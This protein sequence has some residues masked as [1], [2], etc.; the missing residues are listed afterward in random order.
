MTRT[1]LVI[2]VVLSGVLLGACGSSP[3]ASFYT[4]KSDAA[5]APMVS[6]APAKPVQV[7]I[8]AVTIPGVVDRPQIVTLV[9]DNQVALDEFARWGEPL[10][11]NIARAIAGDLARL[12]GSD[13]VSVFDAGMDPANTWRVRVDV[14]R[15]DAT[16]GEAVTIE[17][18]WALVAPGKSVPVVG[19][20][21]VR[22]QMD[23]HGNDALVSAADRAL[24]AVSHDIAAVIQAGSPQ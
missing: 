16:P 23:G 12:L 13:R 18:L 2:L 21:L 24:G 5:L 3:T 8:S 11:A 1:A 17:A 10:K 20:S 15:F 6:T 14:M 4:L 19:R 7:V 22:Q 9:G